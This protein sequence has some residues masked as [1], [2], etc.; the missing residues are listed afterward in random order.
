MYFM[1]VMDCHD[2]IHNILGPN[3]YGRV[4]VEISLKSGD[5]EFSYEDQGRLRTNWLLLLSFI[6]LSA[7]GIKEWQKFYK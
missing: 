7:F 6:F 4:E 2:E 5:D 1:A 3:K